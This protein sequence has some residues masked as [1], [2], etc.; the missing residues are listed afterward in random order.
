VP[1]IERKFRLPALPSIDLGAGEPIRQGYILNGATEL[2]VRA[3]GASRYYLTVKGEGTLSRSEWETEI[4]KDVFEALWPFT[5]RLRLV[6]TRYLVPHGT[7]T[8]EVDEYHGAHTG[9][10][11]LECEFPDERAAR[12]F[13]LPDWAAHAVDV[14]EDPAY[15]NQNLAANSP[16]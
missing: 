13:T 6:K 1:E 11:T 8:L 14:T 16:G 4:P 7:L 12:E 9:L 3:K 10:V 2:R 5:S 15:R